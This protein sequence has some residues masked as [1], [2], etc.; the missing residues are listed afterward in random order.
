MLNGGHMNQQANST[1]QMYRARGELVVTGKRG[2]RPLAHKF[3]DG[4][5]LKFCG[6]C[7]A[8]LSLPSF[9]ERNSKWDGLDSRCGTCRLHERREM[10]RR[11]A[12]AGH[13]SKNR[14]APGQRYMRLIARPDGTYKGVRLYIIWDSMKQ[15]CTN[16]KQKSYPR[17]GGRGITICQAWLDSYDTFRAWAVTHGYRKELTLDRRDN[18]GNYEPANC[19][20]ATRSEQQLNRRDRKGKSPSSSS[21]PLEK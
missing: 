14:L 5:E 4:V 7:R 10:D 9:G 15:R 6:G 17:Y 18:Y 19:R 12:L 20:W 1:D 8:W 3:A 21:L 16:P 11:Y 13:V 2:R